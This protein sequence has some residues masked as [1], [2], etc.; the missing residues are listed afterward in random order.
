MRQILA[1]SL[2]CIGGWMVGALDPYTTTAL[3]YKLFAV[4][5]VA[6]GAILLKD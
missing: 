6:V 5:L 1:C 4:S 2:L 3:L